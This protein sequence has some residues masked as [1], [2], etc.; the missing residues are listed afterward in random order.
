[1]VKTPLLEYNFFL[2]FVIYIFRYSMRFSF[3][4]LFCLLAFSGLKMLR[5]Q[6]KSKSQLKFV[7]LKIVINNNYN[8]K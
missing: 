7:K 5:R 4:L 2:D 1:M 6:N 8:Y 3:M